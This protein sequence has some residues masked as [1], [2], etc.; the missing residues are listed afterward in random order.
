MSDYIVY[1]I[2]KDGIDDVYVGSTKAFNNRKYDHNKR[3]NT[4]TNQKHYNMKIYSII[5]ANGGFHTWN[6][7]KI[8]EIK[9]CSLIQAQIREQEWIEKLRPS[10]NSNKA[11]ETEQTYKKRKKISDKKCYEN[12]REARIAKVK[13][14]YENNKEKVKDYKAE[15]YEKNKEIIKEIIKEKNNIKITCECGCE[16]TKDAL[17]RHLKTKK[18]INLVS[19]SVKAV[20]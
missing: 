14:Y 20:N 3:C 4:P 2:Y 10:M 8:D 7:V 18:H 1:K 9:D 17:T 13:N 19:K 6:M 5:R 16:L 15:Y 12:H 11:H